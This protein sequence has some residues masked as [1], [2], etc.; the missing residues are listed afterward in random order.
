MILSRRGVH[1]GWKSAAAA[2]LW[3]KKLDTASLPHRGV[4]KSRSH[5]TALKYSFYRAATATPLIIYSKE[6][7]LF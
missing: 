6:F 5:R 3:F 7:L 4:M 1:R 2:P